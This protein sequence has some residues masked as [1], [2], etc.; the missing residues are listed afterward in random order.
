M[1]GP[2]LG[3]SFNAISVTDSVT[4]RHLGQ[5]RW[6]ATAGTT[7]K[8]TKLQQ[9]VEVVQYDELARPT[10]RTIE[11]RDVPTAIEDTPA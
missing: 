9:A 6:L 11:W 8:P 7:T 3:F 1:S 10:S 2:I 5:V 4:E